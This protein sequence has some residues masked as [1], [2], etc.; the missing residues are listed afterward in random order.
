MNT[1]GPYF[2]NG[3]VEDNQL[4]MLFYINVLMIA[5]VGSCVTTKCVEKLDGVFDKRS[6][7]SSM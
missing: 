4:T 7:D 2:W 3:N 6:F 5:Y 1:H